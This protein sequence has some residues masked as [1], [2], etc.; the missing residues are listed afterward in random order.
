MK[1]PFIFL[2]ILQMWIHVLDYDRD[3]FRK[4]IQMILFLDFSRNVSVALF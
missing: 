2:G 1:F 4:G 3:S